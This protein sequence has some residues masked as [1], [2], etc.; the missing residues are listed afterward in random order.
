MKPRPATE[1]DAEGVAALLAEL[2]YPTTAAEARQR[3]R[4]TLADPSACVLVVDE[5]PAVVALLAAREST[6]FPS[7]AALELTTGERRTEAHSFYEQLGFRRTSF[8][9]LLTV[10]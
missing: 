4:E 8:R 7:G 1:R 2:G 9:Y 6:Y 3:L 10:Q 5:P